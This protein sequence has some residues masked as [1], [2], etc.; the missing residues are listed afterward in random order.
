MREKEGA[1]MCLLVIFF[2]VEG[3]VVLCGGFGHLV[4]WGYDIYDGCWGYF[5]FQAHRKA[6]KVYNETISGMR[7]YTCRATSGF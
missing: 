3:F 4:W 5:F 1:L 6:W 2:N 7:T